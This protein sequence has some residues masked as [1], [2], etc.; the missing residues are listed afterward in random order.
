MRRADEV[1]PGGGRSNGDH[2]PG[3]RQICLT[4]S[5]SESLLLAWPGFFR[6]HGEGWQHCDWPW[7]R[8][9]QV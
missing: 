3:V 4:H 5:P 9:E 2:R 6:L 8:G 7:Q 1:H